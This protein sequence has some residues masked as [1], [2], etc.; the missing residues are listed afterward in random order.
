MIEP[1]HIISFE[2]PTNGIGVSWKHASVKFDSNGQ[3][4]YW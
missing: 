2:L 4:L 3:S 1:F